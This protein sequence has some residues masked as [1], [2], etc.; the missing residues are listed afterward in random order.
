MAELHPSEAGHGLLQ[1]LSKVQDILH[2]PLPLGLR[3]CRDAQREILDIKRHVTSLLYDKHCLP[4]QTFT[5]IYT[6][7]TNA[8]GINSNKYQSFPQD[9]LRL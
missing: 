3:V 8:H 9:F 5:N 1:V 4:V 7:R 2:G 6:V